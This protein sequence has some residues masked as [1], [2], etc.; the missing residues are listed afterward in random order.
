MEL[1]DLKNSWTALDNRLKEN[2]ALNETII[3]KMVQGKAEKSVSKLLR[4]E[5]IGTIVLVLALPFIAYSI[6]MNHE[7][8]NLFW[9]LLMIVSGVICLF[10]IFWQTYKISILLKI[11]FSREINSTIFHVNRYQIRIKWEFFMVI[12]FAIPLLFTL[13]ILSY[14][15]AKA[16]ISLWIFLACISLLA[17]FI[18]WFSKKKY[19]KTY[20]DIL[21]NINEIKELKEE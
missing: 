4:S 6:E 11:D 18:V 13:G 9:N 5:I 17:M 14:A 16:S 3:L 12:Y 1:E 20:E 19:K 10:A 7:R 15:E 2:N 8:M 21:T